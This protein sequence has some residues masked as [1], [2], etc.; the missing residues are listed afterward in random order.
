VRDSERASGPVL[1]VALLAAGVILIIVGLFFLD[2]LAETTDAWHWIQ[3]G[4]IFAG[5]LA[6]GSGVTM[7][8]IRGRRAA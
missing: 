8:Y 2:S 1:P 5:G 7:L 6:I 4:V 3:H